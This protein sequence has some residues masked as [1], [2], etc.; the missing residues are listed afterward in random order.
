MRL[1]TIEKCFVNYDLHLTK[2][3]GSP[4]KLRKLIMDAGFAVV[5]KISRDL[6]HV[7]AFDDVI[8]LAKVKLLALLYLLT[9]R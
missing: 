6:L 2:R 8:I 7:F 4:E 1:A 5:K 3:E 9:L